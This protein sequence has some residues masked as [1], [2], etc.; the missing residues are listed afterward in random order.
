MIMGIMK[1]LANMTSPKKINKALITDPKEKDIY[2]L[3]DKNSD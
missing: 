3:S 1:N 2:E